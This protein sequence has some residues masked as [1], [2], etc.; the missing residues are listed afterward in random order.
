MTSP[1]TLPSGLDDPL[2]L[3]DREAGGEQGDDLVHVFARPNRPFKAQVV[4]VEA[5]HLER[6]GLAISRLLLWL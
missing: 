2:Q 1:W 3:V 4:G 6:F 5:Q